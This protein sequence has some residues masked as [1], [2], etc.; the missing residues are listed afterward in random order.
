MQPDALGGF[1]HSM[2]VAGRNNGFSALPHDSLDTDGYVSLFHYME[3]WFKRFDADRSGAL[4][5]NEALAGFP[6]VCTELQSMSHFSGHCPNDAWSIETLYGYV[7]LNGAPPEQP[8]NGDK[9]GSVV[10]ATG[11]GAFY[12]KWWTLRKIGCERCFTQTDRTRFADILAA[13]CE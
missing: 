11:W 13:L 3:M 12:T 1:I 8:A 6:V 4:N 10:A 2:E 7:L 5:L 9:W